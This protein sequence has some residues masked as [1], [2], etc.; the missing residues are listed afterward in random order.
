MLL[1]RINLLLTWNETCCFTVVCG[2]RKSSDWTPEVYYWKNGKHIF[3]NSEHEPSAFFYFKFRRSPQNLC[4]QLDLIWKQALFAAHLQGIKFSHP[5][6]PLLLRHLL[7]L[8]LFTLLDVLFC[9]VLTWNIMIRE[10]LAV[11]FI[12][13]DSLSPNKSPIFK[14]VSK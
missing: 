10:K 7:F 12:S 9:L 4:S 14:S 3:G 8:L 6:A 13:H 2:S 11:N 1:Q 5:P